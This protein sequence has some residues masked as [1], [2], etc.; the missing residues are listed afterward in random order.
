M[1]MKSGGEGRGGGVNY[2]ILIKVTS[3]TDQAPLLIKECLEI[4]GAEASLA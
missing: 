3:S 1:G 4:Q 2:T